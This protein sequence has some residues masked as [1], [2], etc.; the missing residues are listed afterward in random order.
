MLDSEIVLL[1]EQ[2]AEI[3][4]PCYNSLEATCYTLFPEIFYRKFGLCHKELFEKL[5]DPA[6]KKLAV[7]AFR[8]IGKTSLILKAFAAWRLLFKLSN[9]I[10]PLGCTYTHAGVQSE[11]LKIELTE[12]NQDVKKLFGKLSDKRQFT[13]ELWRIRF[14]DGVLG[15]CV[16]PR[17][18]KQQVRGL[19][20]GSKRP[21]LWLADD[22]EN[23]QYIE[24]E[25]HRAE[26][27]EWFF[28]DVMYTLDLGIGGPPWKIIVSGTVLHEDT[29]VLELQDNKRWD[30]VNIPLCDD[31]FKS[32]W[33][34]YMT[35]DMV[36]AEY[37]EHKDNKTLDIFYRERM[38]QPISAEDKAFPKEFIYYKQNEAE[39]NRDPGLENIVIVDPA[40]TKK[41]RSAE[42]GIVGVGIDVYRN[43]LKVREAES[44]KMLPDEIYE[45]ALAMCERINAHVL[46]IEVTSLH[47][48]IVQPL[49]NEIYR[50]G[51]AIELVE[52]HAIGH[53]VDRVRGLVP[54]YRKG[55]VEHNK[56][57]CV[58][59]ELQLRGFPKSKR[60]DLMDA[61]A[62]VVLM[63]KEGGRYFVPY[64]N[65]E[66][67][68]KEY[69]ELEKQDEIDLKHFEDEA[70]REE[71][72][73]EDYDFQRI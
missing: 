47:E 42:T 36:K 62:Y 68:E 73:E 50:L 56:T 39:L 27:K 38:N 16:L 71:Y 57:A 9:F 15:G 70:D 59:L 1:K 11:N 69:E 60:W 41:I 63:L 19:L 37:E 6:V 4:E 21:D 66:M 43:K 24:N 48:F 25:E 64:E 67:I 30:H 17:S 28:S 10:V 58:G 3:L 49:Q 22:L 35:D 32:V 8:G 51:L 12:T 46:G 54:Y 2:Q 13:K 53:K 72:Y 33:P 20:V 31:K 34:A 44:D 29:L 61:L 55:Q 26:T 7:L 14:Q 52:L 18:A 45:R 65:E 5:E 23:P 40:K